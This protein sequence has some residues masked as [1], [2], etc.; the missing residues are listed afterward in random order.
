MSVRFLHKLLAEAHEDHGDLCP[1]GGA[2]RGKGRRAGAADD[3]RAAGPLHGGDGILGHIKSIGVAQDI[4]VL[5]DGHII[6]LL[7]GEA[8]QHSGQLLPGDGVIG[9]EQ[10]VALHIVV[11]VLAC[12][13]LSL[14]TADL[15]PMAGLW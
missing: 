13:L 6:A 15:N 11:V 8:I 12:V 2:V 1:R 9:A 7:L 14:S 4:G 3:P 5:T 10:A